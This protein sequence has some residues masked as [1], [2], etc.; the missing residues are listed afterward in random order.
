L[1][2][3]ILTWLANPAILVSWLK[4]NKNLKQSLIASLAATLIALSFLLFNKIVDNE[5][6]TYS[7]II[8]YK[9]GYWLWLLSCGVM[10]IG[11]LISTFKQNKAN[12]ILPPAA[13]TL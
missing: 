4:F 9:S 7:K 13:A 5:G 1:G 11:N 12:V 10:F 3:A 6:G 8:S 2:G